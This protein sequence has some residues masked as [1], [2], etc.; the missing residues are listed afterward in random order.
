MFYNPYADSDYDFP[1]P[2][3]KLS[4]YRVRFYNTESQ[5]WVDVT[6][7]ASSEQ[8]CKDFADRDCSSEFRVKHE[9]VGDSLQII[10]IEEVTLPYELP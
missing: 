10:F 6:V 8:Q 1:V 9:S 5:D 4:R 2:A 7:L 3:T